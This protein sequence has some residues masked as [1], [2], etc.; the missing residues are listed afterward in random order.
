M[1]AVGE[2]G[3]AQHQ[4]G[5]D[6]DVDRLRRRDRPHHDRVAARCGCQQDRKLQRIAQRDEIAVEQRAQV[7]AARGDMAPAHQAPA[8]FITAA[9][10]QLDQTQLL[11]IGQVARG[12]RLGQ[13]QHRGDVLHADLAAAFGEQVDDRRR[14]RNRLD[15]AQPLGRRL[16]AQVAFADGGWNLLRHTQLLDQYVA[17]VDTSWIGEGSKTRETRGR[18]WQVRRRMND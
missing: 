4:A 2:C 7:E 8:Q 17:Y 3:Q 16:P 14:R 1:R 15:L 10:L 5:L 18:Q 12:A 9:A 13:A 11:E 6:V